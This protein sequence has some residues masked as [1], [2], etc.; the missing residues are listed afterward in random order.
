MLVGIGDDM[1]ALQMGGPVGKKRSR[2]K[3]RGPTM[4]VTAD[5]LMDGVDFD[6]SAHA[7]EQIGRKSLAASLS[8]CAA[9][10]VQPRYV[11]VSVALPETWS[12]AK[13]KG[14]YRGIEKLA[15]KYGC[16]IVGGYVY[17]GAALPEL[18]GTYFFSDNCSARLWTL[19]YVNGQVTEFRDRTAELKTPGFTINSVSS[20]GEDAAGELYIVDLGGEVFKVIPAAPRGATPAASPAPK[21]TRQVKP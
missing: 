17:R 14:L 20:F 10:A 12:M 18:H 15:A 3:G 21:T 8:D 7:P 6:T 13:A 16:A 11:L 1:A 5:M 2:A 9:M 4:L 19:R